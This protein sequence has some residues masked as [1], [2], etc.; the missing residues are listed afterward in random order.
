M[1]F[2]ILRSFVICS[3]AEWALHVFTIL[4]STSLKSELTAR[5][6]LK[7]RNGLEVS[8]FLGHGVASRKSGY[9]CLATTCSPPL[10]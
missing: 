8:V 1:L 6:K 3:T 10:G 2:L 9:R 7:Y 5:N 4:I